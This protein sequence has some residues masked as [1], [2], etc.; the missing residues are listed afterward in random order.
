MAEPKT[1]YDDVYQGYDFSIVTAE[2]AAARFPIVKDD[3]GGRL[4]TRSAF[5]HWFWDG[6]A[7]DEDGVKWEVTSVHQ[8]R[9]QPNRKIQLDHQ[10]HRITIVY[11]H[12]W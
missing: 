10:R 8:I 3:R 5:E 9:H 12:D 1:V 4:H 6:I 11:T 2:E 7:I